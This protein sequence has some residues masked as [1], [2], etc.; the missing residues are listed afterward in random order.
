MILVAVTD[1]MPNDI[2]PAGRDSREYTD[3]LRASHDI[4][5]NVSG[6]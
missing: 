6:E 3:E 1:H 2:S 4:V 5:R